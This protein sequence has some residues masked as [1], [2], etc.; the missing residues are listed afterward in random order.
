MK[1]KSAV[2]IVTDITKPECVTIYANHPGF[3]L[4][5]Q[6]HQTERRLYKADMEN[7]ALREAL[8]KATA[9]ARRLKAKVRKK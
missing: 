9:E 7:A 4:L 8:D 2:E 6:M 3:G 1:K 5:H